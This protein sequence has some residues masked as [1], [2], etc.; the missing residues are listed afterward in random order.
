MAAFLKDLPADVLPV[1]MESQD[2]LH[3]FGMRTLGQIAALP[4]GPVQAQ[5]GPEGKR[6]WE[7]ARGHDD[8]PLYPRMMEENIEESTLLTSATVSLDA[9]AGHGGDAAGA[10][11]YQDSP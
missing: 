9:I 1:S 4:P 11:L 2:K 10:G 3:A 6:L 7:L 8:T 5:F